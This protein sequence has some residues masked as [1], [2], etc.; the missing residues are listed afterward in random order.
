M[1]WV[2]WMSTG[3]LRWQT[4]W[5]F[6]MK[7]LVELRLLN[8]FT[9]G[10]R[11][12]VGT[13]N[14]LLWTLSRFVRLIFTNPIWRGPTDCLVELKSACS[15]DDMD[16]WWSRF[17]TWDRSLWLK[18]WKETNWWR[19]LKPTTKTVYLEGR[20]LRVWKKMSLSLIRQFIDTKKIINRLKSE[21]D[22][23]LKLKHHFIG[24]T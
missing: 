18:P 21:I 17:C 16:E 5:I 3:V 9:L 14:F 6:G 1:G 13:T 24:G 12:I 22:V 2:G 19:W 7:V 23:E 15:S 11:M 20:L 4:M 8:T 10:T